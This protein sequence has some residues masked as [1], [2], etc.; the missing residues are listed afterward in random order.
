MRII[1][2]D[3][4]SQNIFLKNGILRVGDFGIAK[5]LNSTQ[6]FAKT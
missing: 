1:H 5:V 3:I 6:D 4:K 2:R